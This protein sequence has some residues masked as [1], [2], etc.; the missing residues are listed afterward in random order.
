[1]NR[2]ALALAILLVA[3]GSAAQDFIRSKGLLSD[4][5]FYRLVACGQQPGG[6]CTFLMRHWP[7]DL[8]TDVTVTKLLDI[9]PVSPIVA[10]QVST[11]I[12][13]AID[14][15]NATGAG[16]HLRRM[17]DNSPGRVQLS[18][19]SHATMQLVSN[20][21]R[22]EN[23]PAGLVVFQTDGPSRIT[24]AV[25]MID[26]DLP[27]TQINSVVLEELTQSLGLPFDIS[28]PYY[29]RRSIFSQERNSV[30]VITGQDAMALRQ[31]YP[32]TH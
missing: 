21:T 18:V 13:R 3:D 23:V 8:A 25:I 24:G 30:T 31:H 1:M 22:P 12:D 16:I 14:A 5:D 26:A 19:R 7:Q 4:D 17:P 6:V 20:E 2:V 27:L 11:A 10:A 28:N 15:L 29:L 32:A 9:D